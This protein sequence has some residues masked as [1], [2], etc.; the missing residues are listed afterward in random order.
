M[1]WIDTLKKLVT[2]KGLGQVAR[3]L[4]VSKTTVSLVMA[5]KYQA[6]SDKVQERVVLVYSKD[7]ILCPVLGRI[8]PTACAD[9]RERANKIGLKAGNPE[10]LRLFVRC[11]KCPLNKG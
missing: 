2:E 9:I 7:G 8:E 10:S 1:E 3:E 4:N 6:S 5:G 11:L